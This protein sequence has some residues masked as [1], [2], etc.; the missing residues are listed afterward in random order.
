[1]MTMQPSYRCS[2]AACT[3]DQ[4]IRSSL[5]LAGSRRRMSLRTPPVDE[6]IPNLHFAPLPHG[7]FVVQIK[8]K[9]ITDH[10]QYPSSFQ[11]MTFQAEPTRSKT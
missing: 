1:M 9:L 3:S 10:S 5:S 7:N 8:S 11:S 6:S 2:L 4:D